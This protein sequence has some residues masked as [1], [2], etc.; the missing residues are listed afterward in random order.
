MLLNKD[1]HAG[2]VFYFVIASYTKVIILT[3]LILIEVDVIV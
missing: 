2:Y 1:V 3:D